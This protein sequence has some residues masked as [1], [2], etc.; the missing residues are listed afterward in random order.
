MNFCPALLFFALF[1]CASLCLALR[2]FARFYYVLIVL[3]AHP[4][5][6]PGS[7]P[8]S[9]GVDLSD[10]RGEQDIVETKAGGG[11][12]RDGGHAETQPGSRGRGVAR[13]ARDDQGMYV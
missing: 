6:P 9:A 2:C 12:C 13:L 8:S 3:A 10:H 1:R 11:G 7:C 5:T 4:T